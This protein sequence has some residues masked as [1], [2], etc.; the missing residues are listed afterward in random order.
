MSASKSKRFPEITN[1][2]FSL[3]KHPAQGKIYDYKQLIWTTHRRT[4]LTSQVKKKNYRKQQT[5]PHDTEQ[6]TDRLK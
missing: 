4:V 3:S 1:F 2:T 5:D 6:N